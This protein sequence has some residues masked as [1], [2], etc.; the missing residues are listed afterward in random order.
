MA[1]TAPSATRWSHS[2]C[3]RPPGGGITTGPGCVFCF[4]HTEDDLRRGLE[5]IGQTFETIRRAL[6]DGD[7]L[8][9]LE[10]P[11]RQSGF[12]RLV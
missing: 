2:S 6:D 12:K 5:I 4:E 7:P 1:S 3:K 11:V 10:C 8:K 9:F